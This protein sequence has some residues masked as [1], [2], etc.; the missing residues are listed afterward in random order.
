MTP[1]MVES[2]ELMMRRWRNYDGKEIDVSEE[3]MLLTAE[4]ISRTAFGSSYLEGE[5]IFKMMKQLGIL[6][7]KIAYKLK[8][9]AI[10]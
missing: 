5:Q 3:F 1:A 6:T 10:R 8:P 4:V 7:G 9:P 2:V